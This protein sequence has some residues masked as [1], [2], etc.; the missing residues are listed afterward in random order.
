M[1]DPAIVTLTPRGVELGERL[2]KVLGRGQVITADRGARQTLEELFHAGKPLVCIMALGIVVRVLGPL[3]KDKTTDPAVVV[4]D[5]MGR[6]A[7]SVLGGH[8]AGANAL[9]EEI[10]AAIDAT[11]VITTASDALG[12]PSV[13]LIGQDWGWK[14]ERRENL[15]QL[16][17]AVV[18]GE[19]IGI[20]Q[21][22]GRTDW[23]N[24]FGE[25][26]ECFRRIETWPP[27]GTWAGLLAI[28]DINL[29][30]RPDVPTVIYRPPML[31]LGVGC[32]RGVPFDEI[33]SLFEDF[34]RMNELSALSLGL[35]A[36]AS[37]KADEPGLLEFA[38]RRGVPVRA[39][40]LDELK[41]VGPLPSP[42]ERV[43]SKI[44][45][46]GVAEPAAMLAAGVNHL[47]V[48]KYRSRRITF[49]V[50]RRN[51]A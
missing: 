33:D 50:A 21:Q 41:A 6:F 47:V 10:G 22:A 11:P 3:A 8:G 13:D 4:V 46:F 2:V 26:P 28:G 37:I 39:F 25:W 34:C 5:E 15:T 30:A 24:V 9:A 19:S 40:T 23:W 43:H 49:A 44:G 16:A 36:T 7:V 29:A 35:V 32:R 38:A 17:A 20:Y 12:L 14:I 51:D 18:R 1:L 48:P 42:S 45:V 27:A 31:V